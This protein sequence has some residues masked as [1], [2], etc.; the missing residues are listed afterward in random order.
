[1]SIFRSIGD[2]RAQGIMQGRKDC[3]RFIGIGFD[4]TAAR[5]ICVPTRR[6]TAIKLS[7]LFI[8]NN[9][10]II[11]FKVGYAKKPTRSASAKKRLNHLRSNDAIAKTKPTSRER[12]VCPLVWCCHWC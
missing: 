11:L 1:M 8:K 12:V 3:C 4:L 5:F 7:F 10:I 2:I 6:V 9:R